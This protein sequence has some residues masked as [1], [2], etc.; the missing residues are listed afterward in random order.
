MK[1][2]KWSWAGYHRSIVDGINQASNLAVAT[3][4]GAKRDAIRIGTNGLFIGAGSGH[5]L[6][7][8]N[9]N[10]RSESLIEIRDGWGGELITDANYKLFMIPFI[11]M[12]VAIE[13][14]DVIKGLLRSP[15]DRKQPKL[16][17]REV[18]L[19]YELLLQKLLATS[20]KTPAWALHH[21]HWHDRCLASLHHCQYLECLIEGAKTPRKNNKGIRF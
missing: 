19:L 14:L 1:A 10:Q 8:S 15:A 4:M 2:R 7:G 21:D 11:G 6:Q 18:T 13:Q 17:G 3:F 9:R 16:V 20:P 5:L 12:I